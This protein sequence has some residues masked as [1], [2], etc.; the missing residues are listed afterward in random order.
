MGLDAACFG[1]QL[2]QNFSAQK[3]I[4]LLSSQFSSTPC[5]DDKDDTCYKYI[6]VYIS[7]YK[8]VEELRSSEA[9]YFAY[10][11]QYYYRQ[12]AALP[13]IC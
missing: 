3:K 1:N 10:R 4:D 13:D 9:S 8:K 6:C 5:V 7:N 12:S 2:T 11:P